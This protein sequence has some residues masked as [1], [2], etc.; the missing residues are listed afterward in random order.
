[1]GRFVS[2]SYAVQKQR[3]EVVGR[4]HIFLAS[5]LRPKMQISFVKVTVVLM[6]LTIFHFKAGSSLIWFFSI[7][8]SGPK[9]KTAQKRKKGKKEYENND[10][11]EKK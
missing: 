1:M 2:E 9:K 6:Y 4:L 10:N 11:K 8:K 5:Y 3:E 7:A